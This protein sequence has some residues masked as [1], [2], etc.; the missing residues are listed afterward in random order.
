MMAY[1]FIIVYK[2]GKANKVAN[3]PSRQ[4]E[5]NYQMM[6]INSDILSLSK[7]VPD[8]FETIQEDAGND[9]HMQ[10]LKQSFDQQKLSSDWDLQGRCSIF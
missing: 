1:N 8:W 4:R 7:V 10:E 9:K 5:G 6:G 3:A 2:Q